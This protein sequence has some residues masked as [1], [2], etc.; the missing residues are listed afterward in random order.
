MK[1]EEAK[2]G[3][4]MKGRFFVC[5]AIFLCLFGLLLSCAAA[6]ETQPSRSGRLRALLI[7]CDYF[8]TKENTYPAAGQNVGMLAETLAADTRN[9]ALIRSSVS[10]I[11]S[12]AAF[13]QAVQDVFGSSGAQDTSLLYISTHGVFEEGVSNADAGVLLSDGRTEALVTGEALERIL[14]EIPGKKIVILDACNSGALIGKGLSGGANRC[15]MLGNSYK[16]LC[17][18]GGSEASW[19]YQSGADATLSGASYFATVLSQGLSADGGYAADQNADGAVSLAEAYAYLCENYAASTPQVYPQQDEGQ[20]LFEYAPDAFSPVQKTITDLYFDETLLTAGETEVTFSFTVHRRT[21]LYYQI[22]Y[23][24]DGVWQFSRAQ[25]FPD[26]EQADGSILPG[27]KI[28]TLALNTGGDVF[29]YAMIQLFTLENGRPLF[30]GTRLLCVQPASGE[31][32]L[33]A[34]TG[35]SFVPA[36]GQEMAIL[37]QHAVPCGLTVSILNEQGRTVRR[38]AYETPSRPQHLSP[39]ASSFYWDG[40]MNNG[41]FAPPGAYTVLVKTRLNDQEYAAQSAPFLLEG[42]W[43]E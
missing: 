1:A 43:E 25:Q 19:Y 13:E 34:L 27:R 2:G 39:A 20:V 11:G 7:G 31:A 42:N 18:A 41:Q 36:L 9:Y 5:A 17:S 6:E 35:A 21:E 24:R 38:L 30:Q 10:A 37:A 16:V 3:R 28:R 29:G 15:F 12:I 23:H 8:V 22:V 26:M 4:E 33:S 32:Q 40:K 14:D